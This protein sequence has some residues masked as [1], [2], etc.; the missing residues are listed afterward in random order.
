MLLVADARI[1]ARVVP[2]SGLAGYWSRES[3]KNAGTQCKPVRPS[4]AFLQPY[5]LGLSAVQTYKT[6]DTGH[7]Q[8]C[9][10]GDRAQEARGPC[11]AQGRPFTDGTYA[12]KTDVFW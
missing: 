1:P 11:T 9:I 3:C 12:R 8:A 2:R 5:R 4:K 7:V 10:E 6:L